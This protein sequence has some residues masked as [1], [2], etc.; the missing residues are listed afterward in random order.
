MLLERRSPLAII[1]LLKCLYAPLYNDGAIN[2]T[3]PPRF[4]F[5]DPP[6]A[7]VTIT[8]VAVTDNGWSLDG[9]A[10]SSKFL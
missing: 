7:R 10:T 6:R 2:F 4:H 3:R 5:T 9:P 8:A 1:L